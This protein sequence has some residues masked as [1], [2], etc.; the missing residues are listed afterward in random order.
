MLFRST[1]APVIP[2]KYLP[3]CAGF[4]VHAGM[5]PF[6]ALQAITLNPARH[7]GVE[8]RVGSLE[9]GKDADVV[10]MEGS[11]FEISSTVCHVFISGEPQPLHPENN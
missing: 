9:V 10:I 8:S 6:H 1:D 5:N 3:L 7:I 2:L 11:C 4:A